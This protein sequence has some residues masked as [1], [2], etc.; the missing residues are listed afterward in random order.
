MPTDS[1]DEEHLSRLFAALA[2]PMVR[3]LVELLALEKRARFEVGKHFD[4]LP[5][6]DVVRLGKNLDEIGLIEIS[7]GDFALKEGALATVQ[8]W[9]DRIKSLKKPRPA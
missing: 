9:L 6:A 4:L 2:N 8:D 3:H 7:H 5:T 1:T